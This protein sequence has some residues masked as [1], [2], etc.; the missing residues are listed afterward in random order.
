[1]SVEEIIGFA[2]GALCV[3]LAVRQN[4]WTFPIGIVNNI[5]YAILF[6][7]TGLYAGATLQVIYLGLGALGWFWWVRGGS[8]GGTLAVR[9]TP[10]L[11]WVLGAVAAVA[12][13]LTLVWVLSTWTDSSAPVL[14][15]V[16]TSLSLVAQ[17]MLGRKWIGNWAVWIV[18]DIIYVALYLSMGLY[19][20][21]I[22]YT[23]F[24]AM[25]AV[26]V[27]DWRRELAAATAEGT[28][29]SDAL[30]DDA[31]PGARTVAGGGPSVGAMP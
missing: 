27:R 31:G 20:T 10:R 17:L 29:H 18:A 9:P 2:T 25:C 4:V 11:A 1:M 12:L 16:T 23:G 26:G 14:D 8:G 22:L 6:T 3:W 15:S 21:A 30:P 28:V 7:S 5:V 19:L 24:I 13:T